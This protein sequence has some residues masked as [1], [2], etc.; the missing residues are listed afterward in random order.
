MSRASW[1]VPSGDVGNLDQIGRRAVVELDD[2]SGGDE[3]AGW[4]VGAVHE[5]LG[6]DRVVLGDRPRTRGPERPQGGGDRVEALV[7]VVVERDPDGLGVVLVE[8]LEQQHATG[9]EGDQ[10]DERRQRVPA[11]AGV[12]VLVVVG[13]R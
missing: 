9:D 6:D 11:G 2:G 1:A 5:V 7:G 13:G 12:T 4:R 3:R 10:G 8:R